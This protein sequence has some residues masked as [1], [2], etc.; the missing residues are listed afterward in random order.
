MAEKDKSSSLVRK[1]AHQLRVLVSRSQPGDLVGFEDD[2][3]KLIGVSR[4]TLR[5]AAAL[6]AQEQLLTVRRGS[7]GGY[8][9]RIPTSKAVAHTAAIYLQAHKTELREIIQAME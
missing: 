1:T 9:A 5:Q 8:F 7:G 3:L 6:V 2:L 4:P